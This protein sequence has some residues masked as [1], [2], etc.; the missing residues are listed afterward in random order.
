[1]AEMKDEDLRH[2]HLFPFFMQRKQQRYPL[3]VPA[4]IF[5]SSFFQT[6]ISGKYTSSFSAILPSSLSVIRPSFLCMY[7]CQVLSLVLLS[8]LDRLGVYCIL[9]MLGF[10]SSFLLISFL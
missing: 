8:I 10:S 6:W 4:F 2:M 5:S 7:A 9:F 1:M 3:I